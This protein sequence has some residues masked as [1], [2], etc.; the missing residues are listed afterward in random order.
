MFGSA[1]RARGGAFCG[2]SGTGWTTAETAGVTFNRTVTGNSTSG[3]FTETL[4]LTITYH[5]H[6]AVSETFG[7]WSQSLSYDQSGTMVIVATVAGSYLVTG[8]RTIVS[9]WYSDSQTDNDSALLV[10]VSATTGTGLANVGF[11]YS[12][13]SE[14]ENETDSYVETG[15]FITGSV[16]TIV[17][18]ASIYSATVTT[19]DTAFASAIS[20]AGGATITTSARDYSP[21][22]LTYSEG[23]TFAMGSGGLTDAG[24][25]DMNEV[26]TDSP[27]FFGSSILS[28]FGWFEVCSMR[29]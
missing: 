15:A 12:F 6:Q 25:F 21:T 5:Y 29:R 20:S 2:E 13:L 19:N 16:G 1:G 8:G 10:D 7:S 9:G 4:N 17:A 11:S 24:W 22:T 26:A 14:S 28:V 23:D 27:S 18:G 3:T